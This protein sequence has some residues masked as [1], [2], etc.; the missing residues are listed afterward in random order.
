MPAQRQ[1]MAAQ[2]QTTKPGREREMTPRPKADDPMHRGSGKLDG[3]VAL[4]SGG[5]SGNSRPVA[6]AFAKEGSDVAINYREEDTSAQ[7]TR[8]MI[9]RTAANARC[10]PE[11]SATRRLRANHRSSGE[12]NWAGATSL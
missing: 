8:Q 9:E 7:E 12:R 3:K 10:C 2:K 1:T 5:D 4:I 6:I 11:M